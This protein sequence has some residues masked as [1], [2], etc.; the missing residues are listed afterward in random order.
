VVFR[1]HLED[2]R[3]A[4]RDQRKVEQDEVADPPRSVKSACQSRSTTPARAA[5]PLANAAIASASAFVVTH[6]RQALQQTVAV[7]AISP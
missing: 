7:G 4:G 3:H 6:V 1:Q 5:Q 2:A